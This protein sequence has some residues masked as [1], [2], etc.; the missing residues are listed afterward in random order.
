MIDD[1]P[2]GLAQALRAE[3][4]PVAVPGHDQ[5]IRSSAGTHHSS[6]GM[7]LNFEPF[8]A[9]PEPVRGR[10]EQVAGRFGG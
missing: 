8:A 4:R 7:T 1:E 9:A 2:G 6:F 10:I 3:P 5:Q